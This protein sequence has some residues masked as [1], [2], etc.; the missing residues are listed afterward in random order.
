MPGDGAE[1]VQ[2]WGRDS[3][4]GPGQPAGRAPLLFSGPLDKTV[5]LSCS[6][7]THSPSLCSMS[8]QENVS[9]QDVWSRISNS[10]RDFINTV[11][12]GAP[13]GKERQ[14]K[15]LHRRQR[16]WKSGAEVE[17]QIIDICCRPRGPWHWG[18]GGGGGVCLLESPRC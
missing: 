3:V 8:R 11:L 17:I 4:W 2:A 14:Q 9:P 5:V 1:H 18:G 15:P 7:P 13:G 16:G 12:I 6:H 10:L